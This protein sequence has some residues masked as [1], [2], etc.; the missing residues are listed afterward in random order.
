M[1][2]L[3]TGFNSRHKVNP[4]LIARYEGDAR[5]HGDKNIK[6][7]LATARRTATSLG[8]ASDVFGH[9]KP[10]HKLALDAATSAM[11]HLSN[12]LAQLVGWAKEYGAYCAK[13]RARQDTAELEA[14]AE[15]RWGNDLKALAFEADVIAELQSRNGRD[16]LGHWMHSIGLHTEVNPEDISFPFAKL[17]WNESYL[18]RAV[19][20]RIIRDA[21]TVKGQKWRGIRGTPYDLSWDQYE[22]YLAHRKA[23]AVAADKVLSGF[24]G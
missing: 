14:I 24:S 18:Q 4:E 22:Q 9:L 11:R 2:T 21:S 6:N 12:D 19:L 15:K 5:W 10:E 13:E 7:E 16:A 23:A 3:M 8:K 1:T 17:S 20:A